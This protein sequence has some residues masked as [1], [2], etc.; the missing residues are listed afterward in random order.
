VSGIFLGQAVLEG[1]LID[2]IPQQL[3]ETAGARQ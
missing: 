3:P 1:V 2:G